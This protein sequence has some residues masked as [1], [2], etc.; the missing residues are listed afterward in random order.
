LSAAVNMKNGE[1]NIKLERQMLHELETWLRTLNYMQQE[2]VYLKNRLADLIKNGMEDTLLE[3]VEYFQNQF[4]NKDAIILLL[5]QDIAHES[6]LDGT[7]T[8]SKNVKKHDKLSKDM[9]MMEKEFSRLK[10]DF[11]NYLSQRN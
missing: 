10:F 6:K 7:L 4:L 2:N 1:T 11:N 3:Q 5:R 9:E 8:E